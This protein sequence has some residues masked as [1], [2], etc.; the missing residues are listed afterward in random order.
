MD[1]IIKGLDQKQ[2]E[3][4]ASWFNEQGEQY[5]ADWFEESELMP[6]TLSAIQ[7][8]KDSELVIYME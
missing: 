6:L 7:T 1:I 3:T 5:L 2:A 8:Q 4:F